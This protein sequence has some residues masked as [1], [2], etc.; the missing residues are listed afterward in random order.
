MNRFDID[1][2][3]FMRRLSA[4]AVVVG[5]SACSSAGIVGPSSSNPPG[6]NPPGNPP[7]TPPIT[8]DGM[9]VAARGRGLVF[10]CG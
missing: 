10:G 5:G 6:G 8:N 7:G 9:I 4:M 1:R 2:R 3:E